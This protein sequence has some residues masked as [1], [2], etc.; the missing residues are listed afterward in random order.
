MNASSPLGA[1]FQGEQQC[2]FLVWAPNVEQVEVRV[3]TPAERVFPLR[4][5][6]R[7]YHYGLVEGLEPG[8]RYYYCLD[9]SVERPDPASSF[10]PEGVHGPSEVIDP[11]FDWEDQGWFGLPLRDYLIYELHVGTFTPEGTFDAIIPLLPE[12]IELGV[13]ALELMPV[14]QFPGARNWGY[15]GVYPYAVQDSYGGPSGLKRLVNAC[16]QCGLAVV[17][18]VVYNHLG[19]EGNYLREFGP[20]FTDRYRTPWGAALNFDGEHSQEVRRFFLENALRWQTQFHLDALRLDAVH[21]IKDCSAR[22]FLQEL[23]QLTRQRSEQLNRRFYLI[24]ESDLNDARLTAPEV[25]GGYG[26]DGQWSD[27]FHHSLHVLLTGERD[28]YYMDFGGTGLLAKVF[29]EGYAYTG[30]YSAY[31]RQPHGNSPRLNSAKQF[32]VY[33]QNH[34]QVGNRRD[35]DRLSRLAHLEGL[36]LAA[37]TVLL[38]PF[39]PLLFMGEEYGEPAP[40]QY[41]ISHTDPELV[42]AVRHGRRAE[43]A[44]FAWP[45]QVPDPHAEST[46]QQCILNRELLRSDPTH[47][48]LYDFYRELIRLRRELPAIAHADKSTLQA[49]ALEPEQVLR[50]LYDDSVGPVCMLCCFA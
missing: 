25:L 38:S 34:D 27:D 35:G 49:D 32:V 47:R 36:K 16:H 37:G 6:E 44:P 41:V 45:E 43:F 21:A 19:P 13:T 11:A 42:E 31:R 8:G 24:A 22:P 2:S 28:G 33:S 3:K 9:Q 14:A 29:R 10:Q 17:L 23:A 30:Q 15:D 48:A 7:G 18:D 20:Y 4:R 26:L 5:D 39:I 12:L 46:F 1:H 50:V 40:F